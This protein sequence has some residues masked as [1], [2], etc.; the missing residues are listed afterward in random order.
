MTSSS[1]EEMVDGPPGKHGHMDS[2]GGAQSE[3]KRPGKGRP[4]SSKQSSQAE[5]D[6]EQT[7]DLSNQVIET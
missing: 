2:T 1:D 4:L 5:T 3:G 7:F 6:G